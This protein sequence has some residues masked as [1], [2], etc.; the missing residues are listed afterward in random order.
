MNVRHDV[1]FHHL[2]GVILLDPALSLLNVGMASIFDPLRICPK[3]DVIPLDFAVPVF[4]NEFVQIFLNASL[5]LGMAELM[6]EY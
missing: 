6:R 4:D 2:K 1:V 3:L 5:P